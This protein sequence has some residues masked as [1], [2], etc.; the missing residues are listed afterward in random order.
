MSGG[1][2]KVTVNDKKLLNVL[3][4]VK[5]VDSARKEGPIATAFTQWRARL[6]T[7]FRRRYMQQARGGGEWP[8]LSKQTLMRRAGRTVGRVKEHGRRGFYGSPEEKQEALNRAEVRKD[9][10]IQEIEKGTAKASI[11]I[12]TG[13]LI[14]TLDPAIRRAGQINQDIPG[15]IRVGM[16]GGAKHPEGPTIGELATK[17]QKG[18]GVPRRRIIVKPD[19]RTIKGMIADMTRAIQRYLSGNSGST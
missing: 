2:F 15:G 4:D 17:H 13:T 10:R 6:L 1:G 11:L 7:F 3:K 5:A 9:K 16:G 8:S 14:G 19:E 12:D 18:I